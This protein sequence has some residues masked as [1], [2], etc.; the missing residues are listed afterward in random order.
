MQESATK[1][2][3]RKQT[4][5]TTKTLKINTTEFIAHENDINVMQSNCPENYDAQ[6]QLQK[7]VKDGKCNK[8]NLQ[9]KGKISE[10]YAIYYVEFIRMLHELESMQDAHLCSIKWTDHRIKLLPKDVYPVRFAQC[11]AESNESR[12]EKIEIAH[13]LVLEFLEQA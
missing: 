1:K 3:Q 2:K 6:I 12:I 9:D 10:Q 8:I 13:M 11:P 5:S 7:P 4:R